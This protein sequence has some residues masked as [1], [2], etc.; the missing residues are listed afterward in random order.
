MT[1]APRRPALPTTAPAQD[2]RHQAVPVYAQR[3][4]TLLPDEA[5]PGE[6]EEW[7]AVTAVRL[8]TAFVHAARFL[9]ASGDVLAAVVLIGGGMGLIGLATH[10]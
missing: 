1:S 8:N 10:L 7:E 2:R 5:V 4:P 6:I 9:N 3:A